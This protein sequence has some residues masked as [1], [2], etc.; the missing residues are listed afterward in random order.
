MNLVQSLSDLGVTNQTINSDQRQRLD[1][2]GFIILPNVLKAKSLDLVRSQLERLYEKEGPGAGIEVHQESGARRLSD[3]VNKGEVFDQI[4]TNPRV[5]ACIHHVIGR[6]FKLSSLNARDAL[7]GQGLQG[8]HADWGKDYDGSFHVC[9]SIWLLDDFSHDNGCTRLVPGS[10][11]KRLP[12]KA[13]DD[14]MKKHPNEEYVIA[15]AGSV[16]VFNSHTWHG[17]TKNTSTNLTRR[18]IH[19]YYTARE[20]QQ[21]LNQQEYLRYETFKRL[22]PAARYILDVDTN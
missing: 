18:A 5:L 1:T 11:K 4:Y 2:D 16:A 20:N 19:C 10:H 9:N 17:G 8:L 12:S 6:E 14:P 22:S 7:P 13:L 21:Q 15:P 3:L